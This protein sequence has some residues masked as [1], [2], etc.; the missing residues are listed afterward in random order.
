[1]TI[2][3]S[4]SIGRRSST[5]WNESRNDPEHQFPAVLNR[6]TRQI[7][8]EKKNPGRE[9]LKDRDSPTCPRI[10]WSR[11]Y[12]SSNIYSKITLLLGAYVKISSV[13]EDS[14]LCSDY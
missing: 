3:N 5:S 12:A 9:P 7:K 11:A 2:N 1:M 8:K 13:E 6:R 10:S 4:L 14:P